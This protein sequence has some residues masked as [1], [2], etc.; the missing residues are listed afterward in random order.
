MLTRAH[1]LSE[2]SG[3]A[4]P[5]RGRGGRRGGGDGGEN[6]SRS[7]AAKFVKKPK[8]K[9]SKENLDKSKSSSNRVCINERLNF[10]FLMNNNHG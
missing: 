2:S 1:Q 6:R 7:E 5:G 8:I 9:A 10:F 3:E 4:G